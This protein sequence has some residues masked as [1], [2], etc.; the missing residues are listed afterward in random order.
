MTAQDQGCGRNATSPSGKDGEGGV[1]R[2]RRVSERLERDGGGREKGYKWELRW[3]V[4]RFI[5]VVFQPYHFS[6]VVVTV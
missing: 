1:G 2:K 3:F 4:F 5:T 6:I